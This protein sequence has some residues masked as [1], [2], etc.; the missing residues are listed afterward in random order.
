MKKEIY[1]DNAATTMPYREV[2]EE[3]KRAAEEYYNPSAIYDRAIEVSRKLESVRQL[4]LDSVSAES[5]TVLFTSGGTESINTALLNGAAGKKNIVSTDYE[6]SATIKALAQAS[7]NGQEIHIVKATDRRIDTGRIVDAVNERTAMV[8]FMHVNNEIGDILDIYELGRS[9]RK[10]NPQ[11]LIHVD[12]VQSYMKLGIDVEKAKIDLMSISGHKIHA[13]K[14]IG[15]LY[16]RNPQKLK[17]LIF[18]GGQERGLRSGTENVVGIRALGKAIELGAMNFSKNAEKL[19]NL[20]AHFAARLSDISDHRINSAA[21]G[22]DHIL[23]VS[24]LGVPSEIL[25]HS[26]ESEGIYVSSGSACSAGK[27]GSHVLEAVNLRKEERASA[28]RFSF[29]ALNELSEI[30]EAIAVLKRS[31]EEIRK[32]TKYRTGKNV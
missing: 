32:F 31:V 21:D 17:P 16:V 22:A 18:G 24:F 7:S 12:A 9:I 29:S 8:S 30:D 3:V 4:F 5:G 1:F 26:L 13:I 11:T 6:H 20:K 25:L 15:A 14:G 10:K 19:K 2:I 28:L 23:N 27:K